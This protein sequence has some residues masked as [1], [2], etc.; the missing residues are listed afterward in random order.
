M[1]IKFITILLATA[2][3]AGCGSG[4]EN[5]ESAQAADSDSDNPIKD[6]QE[7]SSSFTQSEYFEQWNEDGNDYVSREEFDQGFFG[8]LDQ[9]QDGVLSTD[10]WKKGG[11]QFFSDDEV[12]ESQSE[13][14]WD[15][16]GDG[17]IQEEEFQQGIEDI[18][19]F[20]EWDTNDDDQLAE[21]EMAEGTFAMWDTDGNGVIEA[22]EYQEWSQ[23]VEKN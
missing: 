3:L 8:L 12:Q 4:N 15:T 11:D 2:G 22:E 14:N 6:N 9:N 17:Q 13:T 21:E 10:E 7:L 5:S 18:D 20:S 23:K 1:N 19:Y 16:S